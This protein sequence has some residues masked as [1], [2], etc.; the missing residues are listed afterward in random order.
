MTTFKWLAIVLFEP[1][2]NTVH[3]GPVCLFPACARAVRDK[4]LIR[5][6]SLSTLSVRYRRPKIHPKRPIVPFPRPPASRGCS[7]IFFTMPR[8]TG[9]AVLRESLLHSLL[10]TVARPFDGHESVNRAYVPPVIRFPFDRT[11]V[12]RVGH[13]Q[14]Q[15][16]EQVQAKALQELMTQM[17]DQCFNRCAKTS[18]GERLASGEQGCLAMCMDRYE[19][20]PASKSSNHVASFLIQWSFLCRYSYDHLAVCRCPNLLRLLQMMLNMSRLFH[21]A[22]SWQT[23]V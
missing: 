22:Y 17:T 23:P 16:Q 9:F 7:T 4:G 13:T 6:V 10:E 20:D 3:Q 11:P 15:L 14:I 21:P 8:S 12:Y 18:G 1:H 5:A 2:D 19:W